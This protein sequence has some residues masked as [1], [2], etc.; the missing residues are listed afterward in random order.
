[1]NSFRTCTTS[2]AVSTEEWKCRTEEIAARG[3]GRVWTLR[4]WRRRA[5]VL[6]SNTEPQARARPPSPASRLRTPPTTAIHT[7]DC[8]HGR[9]AQWHLAPLSPALTPKSSPLPLPTAQRATHG[10]DSALPPSHFDRGRTYA[11]AV[12]NGGT[13]APLHASTVSRALSP[14]SASP[15][16]HSPV[17]S[18]RS[19]YSSKTRADTTMRPE[20]RTKEMAYYIRARHA[21]LGVPDDSGFRAEKLYRWHSGWDYRSSRL[22]SHRFYVVTG[23]AMPR[24]KRR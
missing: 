24:C 17:T 18:S 23:E 19:S 10:R 7:R 13:P 16:S 12:S 3:C 8:T 15:L 2:W 9:I 5:A 22:L 20:V 21:S 1:M 11:S 4:L 14:A 6:P